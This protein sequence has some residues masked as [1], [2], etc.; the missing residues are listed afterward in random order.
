[1]TLPGIK[2]T[3]YWLLVQQWAKQYKS[4]GCTGVMDF[5]VEACWEHDYHY[6]YGVTL[7]THEPITFEQ[8]NS[9]LR[10]AIQMRSKLRWFSPISWTRYF[11]VKEFGR[12]IWNKHRLA[13]LPPPVL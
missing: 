8:A 13:N 7:L 10:E 12:G 1:M 2:D 9:R 5:Y 11:G 3:H 4:D 6:R